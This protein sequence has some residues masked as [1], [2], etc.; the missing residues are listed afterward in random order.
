MKLAFR[1]PAP[2]PAG[3]SKD[4]Q[5][6][7]LSRQLADAR[8][9]QARQRQLL[10]YQRDRMKEQAV[11]NLGLWA[12]RTHLGSLVARLSAAL[13]SLIVV[14]SDTVLAP[15]AITVGPASPQCAGCPHTRAQHDGWGCT[16][17]YPGTLPCRCQVALTHFDKAK[18][19][20]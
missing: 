15:L 3:P 20:A 6:A 10:S 13:E 14:P 17:V 18:A 7:D 4:Q 2:P 8:T 9:E 5:I 1:R 11:E 16:V 19:A 12:D